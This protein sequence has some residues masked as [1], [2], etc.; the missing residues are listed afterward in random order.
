M[1]GQLKVFLA[2]CSEA[3]FFIVRFSICI[4]LENNKA[5]MHNFC[6]IYMQKTPVSYSNTVDRVVL[7]LPHYSLGFLN[8]NKILFTQLKITYFWH[9]GSSTNFSLI[10]LICLVTLFDHNFWHFWLFFV[11]WKCKPSSLCSQ[12]WM[13]LLM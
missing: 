3:V 4:H 6:W 8:L 9:F 7:K 10:K 5:R 2:F 12:C 1:G 13:R 11:H